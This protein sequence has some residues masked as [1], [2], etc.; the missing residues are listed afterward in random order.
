MGTP[1]VSHDFTTL[2]PAV[3]VH[4]EMH[5]SARVPKMQM[6]RDMN[7]TLPLLQR[8]KSCRDDHAAVLVGRHAAGMACGIE[9]LRSGHAGSSC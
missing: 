7:V 6:G 4:K 5:A 8:Q 1:A 3:W 9:L 2:I